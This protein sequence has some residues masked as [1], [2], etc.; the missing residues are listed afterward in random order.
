MWHIVFG[1]KASG[2]SYRQ[3]PYSEHDHTWYYFSINLSVS[4]NLSLLSRKV[5]ICL[6]QDLTEIRSNFRVHPSFPVT[7]Y[8]IHIPMERVCLFWFTAGIELEISLSSFH[9]LFPLNGIVKTSPMGNQSACIGVLR[10]ILQ[11]SIQTASGK[12]R[13]HKR[14]RKPTKPKNLF[15]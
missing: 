1:V 8:S 11:T 9:G 2:E 14:D 15:F 6:L 13:K 7:Q 12:H 10:A 4:I 3:Y 5:F